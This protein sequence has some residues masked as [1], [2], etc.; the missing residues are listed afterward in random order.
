MSYRSTPLQ[1]GYSPAELLMSS[2]LCTNVPISKVQ[3]KPVVP[4]MFTVREREEDLKSRQKKGFDNRHKTKEL[5]ALSYGEVVWLPSQET[6]AIVEEQIAPRSYELV[7]PSGTTTRRNR[8]DIV[9]LNSNR[10]HKQPDM[11]YK[12]FGYFERVNEHL[13]PHYVT[14]QVGL[15]RRGDVG[16]T[17]INYM[18]ACVVHYYSSCLLF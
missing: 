5:S 17:V 16:L 2:K 6:E 11:I 8:R 18:H 9:H 10:E 13:V 1:N 12:K 7:T 15:E 3:R 14:A 4:D